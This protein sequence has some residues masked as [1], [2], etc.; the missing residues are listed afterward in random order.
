[1]DGANAR[2]DVD[3]RTM[4]VLLH[5]CLGT[6]EHDGDSPAEQG[7]NLRRRAGWLAAPPRRQAVEPDERAGRGRDAGGSG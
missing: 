3:G 2:R 6:A 4:A 1:M 5:R 7:H